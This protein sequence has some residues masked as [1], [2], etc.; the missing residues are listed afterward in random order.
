MMDRFQTI[1]ICSIL[2]CQLS[3][4]MPKP[5]PYLEK[6]RIEYYSSL[7]EQ[8]I[9]REF[10]YIDFE[11]FLCCDIWKDESNNTH[12]SYSRDSDREEFEGQ[13]NYCHDDFIRET[14]TVV[15]TE[16]KEMLSVSIKKQRRSPECID[17][18]EGLTVE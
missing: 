18:L 5:S 15:I 2:F 8:L 11:D 3:C 6:A 12:I 16:S 17:G 14:I 13:L 4:N 1:I 9:T 7:A 10:P